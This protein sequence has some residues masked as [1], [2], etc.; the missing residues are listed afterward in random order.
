MNLE[1]VSYFSLQPNTSKAATAITGDSLVIKNSRSRAAILG[2]WTQNQVAGFHQII[3]PSLHDTTRNYRVNANATEIDPRLPHGMSIQPQPQE[4]LSITVSGS[5]VA[6]A[7][8]LGCMLVYYKDLPGVEARMISYAEL[9]KKTQVLTTVSATLTGASNPNAGYTGTELIN[10]ESD[11]LRANRDYAVLG[12]TTSLDCGAVCMSGPDFGNVRIGVPG[13]ASDNDFCAEY[14]CQL[15][16]W[17]GMSLIPV[18]NSGN[19]NSMNLSF[20][21]NENNI[22]PLVTWY[23]ALLD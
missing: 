14:F 1:L 23:L 7:Y 21:Q 4:T 20:L 15:S 12:A 2:Y 6:T 16:R 3:A 9:Q 5:N 10:A 13:D 19:R 8:E 18:F 22:S 17:F 11:L